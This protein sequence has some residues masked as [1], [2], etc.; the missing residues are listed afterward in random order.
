MS[1]D[2]LY[3]RLDA[4]IEA[5]DSYLQPRRQRIAQLRHDLANATDSTTRLNIYHS[6]YQ[7]YHP[8]DNDSAIL[9]LTRYID[10]A[11]RQ[12]QMTAA[13]DA[14]ALLAFQCSNAG[15]YTES[16]STL[17]KIQ[18]ERLTTQGRTDY[19]VAYSHLY[20]ELGYYSELPEFRQQCYAKQGYYRSLIHQQVDSTTDVW[21]QNEEQ[22]HYAAGDFQKALHYNDIRLSKTEPAS[23][24]Y[25]IVTY[26]R[27]LDYSALGDSLQSR[28]WVAQSALADVTNAV[29]DQGS[30]WELANLL[31]H[32]GDLERSHRYIRYAWNCALKFNTRVR[33]QQ[34]SPTLSM[35]DGNYQASLA[36]TNR[37]LTGF[38]I[39]VS[40]LSAILLAMLFYSRQ[41][42][43][44]LAVARNQLANNN[45]ELQNLNAQQQTLNSKLQQ[46]NR[47][48]AD[49]NRVKDEYVGRFLQLCSIYIDRMDSLRYQMNKL[50]K[51]RDFE[52]LNRLTKSTEFKEKNLAELHDS[53]DK[54]FL[55]LFPNFVNDFNA[56][57]QPEAQIQL[58][59]DNKLNTTIRI[60]ALIRLGIDDSSKIAEFLHYSVNTI[61]NYRARTKNGAI[62]NRDTFESQVKSIGMPPPT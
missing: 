53:F 48:L 26:Y 54:A 13:D 16:M 14:R 41:Q 11:E 37:K 7:Q 43:K 22:I 25:A 8:Y 36:S 60:F 50:V 23:H 35:I 30:V 2:T 59:E 3:R 57:L 6:L 29:T 55:H 31:S 52:A 1:L 24:Q 49:S 62:G 38:G 42:R 28:Y 17:D 32:D 4:A 33:G 9:C 61:Y 44:K 5:N 51:N 34:V 10:L 18:P 39:A 20:G 27:Y 40:L 19:L 45:I 21:L 15:L 12:G 47:D 56:L 46:A 58:T